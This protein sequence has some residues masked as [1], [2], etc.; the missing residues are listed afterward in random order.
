MKPL[1]MLL[2]SLMALPAAELEWMPWSA[3]VFAQAKIEN[4]LV[5]LDLEAVWCHWCHVMEATTYKD[6]A[7]VALLKSKYILVRVDQDSRPDLSN[8]YEDYGWPATVVFNADGQE[9][10]KRRGYIPPREMA[11]ML[12]AV[13]EDPTPGPS[14]VAETKVEFASSPFLPDDLKKELQGQYLAGYDSKHGSWGFTQKYLDWD[15]VEYALRLARKGD[16]HA[17]H[18]A[19]QTLEAQLRLIDPAWGGVYQYST[20]GGWKEPHFEKIMQMQAENLR[21]YSL[22][23]TQWRQPE[24]LKAALDIHRFLKTFLM[25][26]DGAFYT[27][28]NADVVDGQHSARYFKLNDAERRKVGIPRIDKHIYSRE[29]GWAIHALSALYQATGDEAYLTEAKQ[30]A[31]W[32]IRNRAL[33][34]G[35]FR[36]D[37]VDASGPYLGDTLAMARAFMSLYACTSDRAWLKRSEEALGFI[38]ANFKN[39]DGAGFLTAAAPTDHAY[40]PHPERDENVTLARVANL[41][42]HYS[43][44]RKI[45]QIAEDAMRYPVTPQIAHQ[46]TAV[47]LLLADG[48]LTAA[49][50]HL[51]IVGHKD[52]PDAHQLFHKALEYPSGYKRVEW[53]DKREGALPN[54]DVEYPELK[55]AAAFVC[56]ER[57]CSS[58][59][60]KVDELLAKA[61]K[62]AN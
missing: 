39:P 38:A 10:V 6:P 27:S 62:L 49:P 11:S 41:L 29:N 58:P 24:Y 32:V 21:I 53:W 4:R 50:V 31:E 9:I 54:A 59:I 8:R 16:A 7:T 13:I 5:L 40:K 51:T 44:D 35:G 45:R 52:D 56:T 46:Y 18:M 30:A 1:L 19:R 43:G 61:E 22:A 15:G 28:Q 23:Y 34:G 33:A 42:F 55:R 36:H 57:S 25:T 47:G 2:G 17:E 26:A 12:K 48:E 60:V 3:G 37:A 20:G 14:V